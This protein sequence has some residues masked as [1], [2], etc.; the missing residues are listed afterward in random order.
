M[1]HQKRK[2]NRYEQQ[3]QNSRGTVYPHLRFY[4]QNVHKYV[5]IIYNVYGAFEKDMKKLC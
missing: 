3:T 5:C 4:K 1:I 2:E